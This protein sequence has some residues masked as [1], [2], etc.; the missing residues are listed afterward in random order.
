VRVDRQ[1]GDVVDGQPTFGPP[2]SQAG[3]RTV[4]MPAASATP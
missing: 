4:P 1:L 2:K 3:F